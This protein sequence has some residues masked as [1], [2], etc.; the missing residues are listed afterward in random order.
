[1]ASTPNG[2]DRPE[3]SR[4]T[5]TSSGGEYVADP[6]VAT[7]AVFKNGA[8]RGAALSKFQ[9]FVGVTID[10]L[11]CLWKGL[12]YRLDRCTQQGTGTVGDR[13]QFPP[14]LPPLYS[15][16]QGRKSPL[17]LADKT[18]HEVIMYN[19]PPGVHPSTGFPSHPSTTVVTFDPMI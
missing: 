15:T 9:V 6:A 10:D 12:V 5:S 16:P 1:M 2:L 19:I 3:A 8:F 7:P 11:L 14:T 17:F 18:S 4:N 13:V